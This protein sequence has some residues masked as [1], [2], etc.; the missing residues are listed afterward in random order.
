MSSSTSR[1]HRRAEPASGQLTL[2]RREQVLGVVLLDLEV[3]VAGD[4]EGEVLTDLHAGEQVVQV[5]GDDVLER[6]EPGGV[7]VGQPR[8][9]RAVGDAQHPG[10]HGRHLDPGEVLL[11]GARVDQDDREVQGE[12]GDV[13]ERVRRVDGERE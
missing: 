5:G 13:R 10:E 8:L 1:P 9:V 6:H 11:A 12:A 4:P 2:Q 7:H 3:L